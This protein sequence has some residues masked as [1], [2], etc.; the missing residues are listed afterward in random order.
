MIQKMKWKKSM[1]LFQYIENNKLLPIHVFVL[2]GDMFTFK[3]NFIFE[4]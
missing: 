3:F 4:I 2:Q 1:N